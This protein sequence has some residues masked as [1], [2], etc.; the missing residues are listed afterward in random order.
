MKT[1]KI[2][3]MEDAINPRSPMDGDC[4]IGTI[5]YK[6]SRYVLGEEEIYDPI[7]Y[8]RELYGIAADMPYTDKTLEILQN[9]AN[10]YGF[11]LLPVYLYDHSGLSISTT[12][13]SCRWDSGQVGFIYTDLKTVNE[14][15]GLNWKRW[16]AKRR[17]QVE[18]WLKAE[19]QTFDYYMTGQVYGFIV[20]EDG[21]EIDSCW[22]FYGPDPRTNGIAD[23]VDKELLDEYLKT[24]ML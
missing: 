10:K 3:V 24:H 14:K 21:E 12:P 15:N 19:L 9:K 20:E 13:F 4:N 1:L 2:E 18:E 7:D 6:H 5:A 22:G 8:L 23:Y 16:S 17:K 11:V